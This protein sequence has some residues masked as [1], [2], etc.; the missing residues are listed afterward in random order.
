M[1]RTGPGPDV[2]LVSG[3]DLDLNSL[4]IQ[5][6]FQHQKMLGAL[7]Y[8]NVPEALNLLEYAERYVFADDIPL[9][10]EKC[11]LA[12]EN[13]SNPDFSDRFEIRMKSAD[14][15]VF[16]FLTNCWNL[17]E[18]ILKGQGQNITDLKVAEEK[19]TDQTASLKSVIENTDDYVFIV[20]C[21]GELLMFNDHFRRV[22]HD[23][24]RIVVSEGINIVEALPEE[25]H[26]QW[27]PLLHQACSGERQM[28]DMSIFLDETYHIETA[29]NP[30][31]N[32]GKISAVSFFVRDI[33]ARWRMKAWE[34]LETK[35]FELAN[36]EEN[37]KVILDTLV[38][39]IE[40]L[41][42]GMT[43]Y[44]TS[45]KKD[46]MALEWLSHP[47]LPA[48]YTDKVKEIPI[49]SLHGSCGLAAYSMEPVFISN[50]REHECWD[51][52]RDLTLLYGF[53]SCSAFPIISRDGQVLGTLGAYFRSIHDLSDFESTLMQRAV[54]VV[55]VLMEKEAIGREIREKSRQLEEIS[56][57]IPGVV[58]IIK[59]SQDG[60]R[61]FEY[62]SDRLYEFTNITRE[63]AMNYNESLA[64]YVHPRF[65]EN[66]KSR[67]ELSIREKTPMEIEFQLIPE[68]KPEFHWFLIKAVHEY[69]EDGVVYT[70]GT[71]YDITRQKETELRLMAKQEEMIKLVQCLDDMVFILDEQDR[72]QDAFV[73]D[74]SILFMEKELFLG[75]PI[76]EVLPEHILPLYYQAKKELDEHYQSGE[77]FYSMPFKDSM[78][79]FKAR[80]MRMADSGQIIVTSKNITAEKNV[81]EKSRK[82]KAI[83]DE[84]GNYAR[85]GSFEFNYT[86][87]EVYWSEHLFALLGW[88]P[89]I[90][91]QELYRKYLG[92]IHPDDVAGLMNFMDTVVQTG[93][94]LE[95]EHRIR[96]EEGGYVW[97]RC[98]VKINAEKQEQVIQGIAIDITRSKEA[99]LS[100]RK[101]Q[102]LMEAITLFSARLQSDKELESSIRM[103][104]AKIGEASAV[105]RV[106]VFR[107]SEQRQGGEL[108]T[109][110][111]LE[112]NDQQFSSQKDNEALKDFDLIGNG[113]T[114]WVDSLSSGKALYG[115]V[116]EFPAM[117]QAALLP[118]Q[119]KSLLVVPVMAGEEWWGF[120][121][122]DECRE[123]RSWTV[124]EIELLTAVADL[125]GTA[126]ER[127][128]INS[129]ILESETRFRTVFD[130]MA[131]GVIITDAKGVHL[132]CNTSAAELLGIPVSQLIGTGPFRNGEGW[133][134]L[135]ADGTLL[136]DH[137]LPCLMAMHQR[138]FLKDMVMGIAGGEAPVKW[139]SLNAAPMLSADRNTVT[140]SLV[141]FCDV[142]ARI[143]LEQDNRQRLLREQEKFE[144]LKAQVRTHFSVMSS[145][146]QLEQYFAATEHFRQVLKE[147]RGRLAVLQLVQELFTENNAENAV[148]FNS[149][150]HPL[151]HGMQEDWINK[152]FSLTLQTG[153]SDTRLPLAAAVSCAMIVHEVAGNSM[154]HA[155][156]GRSSGEIS[157]SLKKQGD[158]YVLELK[159]N[160]CGLPKG[161]DWEKSGT[162]GFT[163]VRTWVSQL[164][165][166]ATPGTR[167]GFNMLITFPGF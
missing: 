21:E 114:R 12:I 66:F 143:T 73:K 31:V 56:S 160:G 152:D 142:T 10:K 147:N 59:M 144:E 68:V 20:S 55:G 159:D 95:F 71:I 149:W 137:E 70:Y 44:V 110:Q 27:V 107:N 140:G 116:N 80:L 29:V 92:A 136:S 118:Q 54:N 32:A 120:M 17:R 47:G 151:L 11:N 6:D 134:L 60:Q 78:L 133:K 115:N 36:R 2:Y 62:V 148:A 108:L 84:A 40:L 53:Q 3:W 112:W 86:R 83:L 104:L 156:K 146:L 135:H 33:T 61:K 162:L 130:T 163:L 117:E 119:I 132:S 74:E 139:L 164:K 38:E 99:E 76:N 123:Y 41:S 65:L 129:S 101:R 25:L 43:C 113:F 88:N 126:L 64:R 90:S 141:T 26:R 128:K 125:I 9:V 45:R 35:V 138:S 58:Y 91:P 150:I 49:D 154:R 127:K 7:G 67:I 46:E 103:M 1:T 16:Y 72:F 30:I 69:R 79:H 145:L 77:F 37:I 165:G 14:H 15:K 8:N 39:G 109:S 100:S 24:F 4:I 81:I 122:F 57:S 167:D 131:E 19:I 89:D 51:T 106:Y 111:I 98:I 121:G 158:Y 85:F 34:S 63:E 75:E 96:R 105:N 87:E 93:T 161:Y 124:E 94:G 155:F 5:L 166:A 18:G 52:Y 82:L 102:S 22:L 48:S 42:P 97:F 23:F 28:L 50:I 13:R 157:V 153:T